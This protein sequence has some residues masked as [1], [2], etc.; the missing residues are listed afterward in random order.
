MYVST[1][2]ARV[3]VSAALPVLSQA[4]VVVSIII[5]MVPALQY[6]EVY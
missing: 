1:W 5:E 4:I 6:S 3:P 2:R